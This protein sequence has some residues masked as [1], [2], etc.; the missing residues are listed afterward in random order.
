MQQNG[1]YETK[2]VRYIIEYGCGL[3]EIMGLGDGYGRRGGDR[4]DEGLI[5][6]VVG[7]MGFF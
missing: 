5:E 1:L 2:A 4:G 7:R 6:K 3:W